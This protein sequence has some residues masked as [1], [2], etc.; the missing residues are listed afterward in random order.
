MAFPQ[1]TYA[2]YQGWG[3]KLG[4]EAFGASLAAATALV[5]HIVGFNEV[6]TDVREQAAIR[7][8]CAAVDV[9]AA[10]GATG[11]IG[12]SGGGFSIGSFRMDGGSDA[13]A[14]RSAYMA[15][16]YAAVERELSGTGLLFQG[17]G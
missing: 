14:G 11:G 9:D 1:P 10:Y 15:D 4:E 8:V 16:L 12:E 7:A 13:A 2:Q 3:G 17:V 6:D 5:R